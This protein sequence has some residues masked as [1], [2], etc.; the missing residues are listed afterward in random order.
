M[1]VGI[2]LV[3]VDRI[4]SIRDDEQAMQKIFSEE[5][6]KSSKSARS[7]AGKFAAKEAYFKAIGTIGDWHD[8]CVTK[9][10]NG[11][12]SLVCSYEGEI[13]LSISHDGDYATAIVIL[14]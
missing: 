4:A 2:D 7:L 6:I 13:A 12:P 14:N 9:A 3:H 11:K 8:A 10:E 5:E 1:K